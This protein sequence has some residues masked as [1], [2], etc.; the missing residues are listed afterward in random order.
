MNLSQTGA[1]VND[2]INANGWR[3]AVKLDGRDYIE[4]CNCI[5]FDVGFFVLPESQKRIIQRNPNKITK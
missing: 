2:T 4:F 3:K 5:G 1:T